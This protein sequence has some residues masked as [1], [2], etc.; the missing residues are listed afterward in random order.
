MSIAKQAPAVGQRTIR[1]GHTP[2]LDDAFMFYALANRKV[3]LDGCAVEHVIDDIQSLNQRALGAGD[4]DVTAVS[5]ASY[6][7]I[8]ATHWIL[9]V[10]RSEE[11]TSELQSQ[12]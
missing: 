4:L 9:S 8:A 3:I 2:D 5:A 10:G 12:R 7:T 11:H 1:I 6:P